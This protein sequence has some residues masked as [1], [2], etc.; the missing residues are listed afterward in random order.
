MNTNDLLKRRSRILGEKTALFYD[1]PIHIVRGE[2]VWLFDSTGKRYLDVYNNVPN[3][4]HCH[5]HVVKALIKQIETLNIHTR[6]L[7]ETI[8][9]YG[10]RLTATFDD[11]LSMIIFT[12]T[13][14][15]SNELAL[16]IARQHTGSKGIICSNMTYHGNTA[17]VDELATSFHGFKAIGPNVRAVPFPDSYRPLRE[18]SGE[19]LA[20][21]YADEVKAAINAFTASDVGFAGMLVCPIFANEGVPDIPP[22][23]LE[24]VSQYV[25]DAGG[26]LIFDEVQ[27]GF[28][29][30]GYM[31]GYQAAG[32]VPDIVTLGKPMGNGHPIAAVVAGADLINEFREHVMYF[33]TFSGN[34]VSCAAGLAVLEVIENENLVENV[35]QVGKSLVEGLSGLKE[36]YDLI[37]DVRSR[38][39]FVCVELVADRNTKEPASDEARRIVN[40]MKENGVLISHVGP[41]KNLL[42]I[43]PPIIFSH[44]NAAQ[45]LSTLD[46]ALTALYK[47]K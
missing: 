37:G 15:E 8:V 36:K 38:G 42:K 31:W 17:A 35:C 21:A 2:G 33:N 13:G 32:V 26:L 11:S 39:L 29:R 19:A 16:R 9:E 46:Q 1:E 3:V 23:Y 20:D 6:Y 25:H 28:G 24:K 7:H 27:S 34:P 12:C 14:S 44:N 47:D 5:P 22:G 43:R 40:L 45:V 41:Y 30:T 18:L 10:E 4:G